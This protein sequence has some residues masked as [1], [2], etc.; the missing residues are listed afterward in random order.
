MSIKDLIYSYLNSILFA[1]E[2]KL[3]LLLTL[4]QNHSQEVPIER[5]SLIPYLQKTMNTI[6]G[7]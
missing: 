3:F 1:L 2:I 7:Q 4:Q 6:D 5:V